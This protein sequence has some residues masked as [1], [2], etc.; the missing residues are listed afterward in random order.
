MMLR[1]V[2]RRREFLAQVVAIAGII[3]E[4]VLWSSLWSIPRM[5]LEF[6]GLRTMASG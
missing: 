3:G 1:P 4:S 6:T 2:A 5:M